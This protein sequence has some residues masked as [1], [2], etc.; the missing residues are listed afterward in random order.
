[1][2]LRWSSSRLEV[3]PTGRPKDGKAGGRK[4]DVRRYEA[5]LAAAINL[6]RLGGTGR[7]LTLA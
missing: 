7:Q 2:N 6:A 5:H 4:I 3:Y 1:M